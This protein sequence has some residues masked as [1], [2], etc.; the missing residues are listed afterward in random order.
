VT[1]SPDNP[2]VV[3]QAPPGHWVREALCLLASVRDEPERASE[4]ARW[5]QALRGGR[6][7]AAG[8]VEARRGQRLVGAAWSQAHPGGYA[9]LVLPRVVAGEP[10]ATGDRLLEAAVEAAQGAGVRLV[11]CLM[12]ADQCPLEGLLRR[13]AFT[14]L[15]ELLYLVTLP[16]VYP[17]QPPQGDWACRPYA[18]A[19]WAALLDVVRRSY[20][21]TQDCPGL[22]ELR[23]PQDALEGYAGA[24][25]SGTQHWHLVEHGREPVG[26]LLLVDHDTPGPRELVY[27]GLVPEVRGRGWGRELARFAQWTA[28]RDG[29]PLLVLAVDRANHPAVGAY[30]AAGFTAWEERSVWIRGLA[31]EGVLAGPPTNV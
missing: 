26:C 22:A 25:T 23:T 4:L 28:R 11:Q 5:E 29:R 6:L 7:S 9:L 24:G 1:I 17:E 20:E 16:E 3:R 12:T 31:A 13:H 8:L 14:R 10:P 21:E 27:L 15:A 18:D 2:L 30:L 19:D